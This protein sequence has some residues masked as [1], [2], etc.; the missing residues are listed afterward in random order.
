[1]DP[2]KLDLACR[3]SVRDRLTRYAQ[4]FPHR[5]AIVDCGAAGGEEEVDYARLD[6]AAEAVGR[7]LLDAGATCQ[8]PVAFMLGNSWRFSWP[9]PS[10]APRP[11]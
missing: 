6:F 5:T 10:A 7:G 2:L 1:M 11:A 8:E 3:L 9:P 4:S